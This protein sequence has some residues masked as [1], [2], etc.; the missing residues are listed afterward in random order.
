MPVGL[1]TPD[2]LD[3]HAA[4]TVTVQVSVTVGQVLG[5]TGATGVDDLGGLL[6]GV[7]VGVSEVVDSSMGEAG[8]EDELEVTG[9]TVV[10]TAM[11]EVTTTVSVML[12]G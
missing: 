5:R 11:T 9:Q 3:E 7:G 12:S 10:E 4:V 1:A 8:V 2:E 6:L